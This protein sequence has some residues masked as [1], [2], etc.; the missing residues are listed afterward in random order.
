MYTISGPKNM[1]TVIKA[2]L[3]TAAIC[4]YPYL[5]HNKNYY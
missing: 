5:Q 4:D 3:L 2:S 1:D